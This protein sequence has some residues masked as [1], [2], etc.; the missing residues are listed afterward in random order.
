MPEELPP[1]IVDRSIKGEQIDAPNPF[2]PENIGI[3]QFIMLAR[4]YDL[5]MVSLNEANPEV[6]NKVLE[7]HRKGTI[8]GTAPV[9]SGE[10]ASNSDENPDAS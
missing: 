8:L 2:A 10:F 5:L 1:E 3:V 4:I 7:A 6:A 9:L